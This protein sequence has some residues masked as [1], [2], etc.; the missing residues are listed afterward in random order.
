MGDHSVWALFVD[1]EFRKGVSYLPGTIPD[2]FLELNLHEDSWKQ[3]VLIFVPG[4][5]CVHR[6]GVVQVD[7]FQGLI[8]STPFGPGAANCGG[9]RVS[10]SA[11]YSILS[12]KSIT[13]KVL[14]LCNDIDPIIDNI[15]RLQV[16]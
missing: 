13:S 7:I 1:Y 10:I 9:E 15:C 12:A 8:S 14:F 4:E 11:E 5:W 3:Y 16:A 2:I 6:G